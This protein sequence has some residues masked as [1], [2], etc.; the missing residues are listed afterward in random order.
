MDAG[1]VGLSITYAC[2]FHISISS[3]TLSGI[4][5]FTEFVLWV[6]RLYAASEM[7]MNSVERVAECGCSSAAK[8]MKLIL[9]DLDLEIEEEV[10][11]RGIEPPAYWPSREGSVVVENLYCHYA[12]QVSNF[13]GRGGATKLWIA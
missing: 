1:A 7:S 3:S 12:P 9:V 5:S 6:V 2:E 10:T 13:P 8:S 11:S 4:V